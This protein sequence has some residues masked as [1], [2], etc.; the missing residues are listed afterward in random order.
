M[1]DNNVGM[2]RHTKEAKN[3]NPITEKIA[4]SRVLGTPLDFRV[5]IMVDY[6]NELNS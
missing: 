1:T 6:L 2:G 5:E 3:T 4:I